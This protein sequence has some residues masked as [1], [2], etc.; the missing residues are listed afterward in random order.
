[1]KNFIALYCNTS[2]AHQPQPNLT[3]EQKNQM[4]APWGAWAA[5]C[6]D[7]LVSMGTPLAPASASNNGNSW[8]SSNNFVTGY[9]IVAAN[10]LVEAQELFEGHPIFS[11]P[12]HSVEI[13][14]C[15]AM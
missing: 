9:S 2:G 1:M 10:S 11:Y 7:R 6:G 8:S 4:M 12:D 3:P 13:S 14:E 15:V 5:R